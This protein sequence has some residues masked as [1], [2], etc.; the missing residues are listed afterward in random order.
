LLALAAYRDTVENKQKGPRNADGS[1]IAGSESFGFSVSEAKPAARKIFPVKPGEGASQKLD[2]ENPS[3]APLYG[4]TSFEVYPA[5]GEQPRQDRGFAVS[6]S[7][8][9]IAQDG[10]LIPAE[11]LRVGDRVIVTLRVESARPAH[12]VAIDDP[13]PSIL[14][15]VNPEFVSRQ[16]G[17]SANRDDNLWLSYCE[18]RADRVLY[19]CDALP[20]GAHTFEYLARVRVAGKA[21][22]GATKAEAMYRPERFGLGTIDRLA[23]EPVS[24]P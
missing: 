19:F 3:G 23:S 13:L 5:L 6:R 20:A 18:T 15:A 11:N 4:E 1:V 9:K 7:Y 10:S 14:E 22:A 17:E 21:A 2:V 8:R 12:F 24:T 16:S